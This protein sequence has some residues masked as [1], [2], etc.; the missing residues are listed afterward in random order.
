MS[1]FVWCWSEG[2]KR[3]YSMST[4]DA[5]RALKKGIFVMGIKI[6]NL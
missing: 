6:S 1:E 3:V 5:E 2:E 4:E